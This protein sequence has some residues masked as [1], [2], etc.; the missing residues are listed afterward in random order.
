MDQTL[1]KAVHQTVNETVNQTVGKSDT[2]QIHI[3]Y[4]QTEFCQSLAANRRVNAPVTSIKE[5]EKAKKY[6]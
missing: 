6:I 5:N 4:L 1:G 3:M 2:V